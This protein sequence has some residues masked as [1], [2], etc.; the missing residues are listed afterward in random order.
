M[1]DDLLETMIDKKLAGEDTNHIQ[2]ALDQL[3]RF[4]YEKSLERSKPRALISFE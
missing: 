2:Y 3:L 4:E 1:K